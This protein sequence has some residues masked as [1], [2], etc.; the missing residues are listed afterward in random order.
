MNKELSCKLAVYDYSHLSPDGTFWAW[1]PLVEPS[2]LLETLL[3]LASSTGALNEKR[4]GD[5]RSGGVCCTEDVAAMFRVLDGGRDERNR[6]G[7]RVI[8][9]LITSRSSLLEADLGSLFESAAFN[10]VSDLALRGGRL[11]DRGA[12]RLGSVIRLPQTLPGSVKRP[13]LDPDGCFTVDG[14]DALASV[15][16]LMRQFPR[17]AVVA[18]HFAVTAN[19]CSGRLCSQ[20]RAVDP[21]RF[22]ELRDAEFLELEDTGRPTSSSPP[23]GQGIVSP[24][25]RTA[26]VESLIRKTLGTSVRHTLGAFLIVGFICFLVGALVGFRVGGWRSAPNPGEQTD[27]AVKPEVPSAKHPTTPTPP[28]NPI[29]TD[30]KDET[31]IEANG[32]LPE[33][34]K[35]KQDAPTPPEKDPPRA[36]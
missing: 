11:P 3:S 22:K 6:P 25:A 30:R 31:K 2:S 21:P 26:P 34:S 18:V 4:S 28:K 32:P 17:S 10:E 7:R 19:G 35:P 23:R 14:R 13:R 12:S 29:D 33:P 5:G 8:A 9:F 36:P 1:R 16:D 20:A 27:G 15:S 24:T